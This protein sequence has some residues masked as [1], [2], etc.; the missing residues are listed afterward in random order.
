MKPEPFGIVI[1]CSSD[2]NVADAK[3][4]SKWS[5]VLRYARK[6]KPTG[7]R[8][9]DFIKSNGGLNEWRAS[10]RKAGSRCLPP[11]GSVASKFLPPTFEA[12]LDYFQSFRVAGVLDERLVPLIDHSGNMAAWADPNSGWV[13]DRMGKVFALVW[14][15]GV[16]NQT[17]RSGRR[18]YGDH[19]R[20]RYGRVVLVRPGTKIEDLN[21]PRPKKIPPPPKLHLP[22]AHPVL[23]WLPTPSSKKHQW[24]DF[25]SLD[26]GLGRLRAWAE[27]RRALKKFKPC[28]WI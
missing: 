27:K 19:I 16:F 2:P 12:P 15:A 23:K 25:S 14:F 28:G 8:L 17:R 3:T 5:R 10:S 26:D 4:R 9:A 6:T 22:S 13:S 11:N 24:A 18:W 20:D 1:F 21:M 7:Q